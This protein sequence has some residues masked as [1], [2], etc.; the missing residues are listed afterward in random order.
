MCKIKGAI[1]TE[2]DESILDFLRLKKVFHQTNFVCE[3]FEA[4][5]GGRG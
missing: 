1:Y 2:T 3:V 5:I 4:N